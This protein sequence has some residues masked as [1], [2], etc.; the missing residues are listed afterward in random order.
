MPSTTA[1]LTYDDRRPLSHEAPFDPHDPLTG[2]RRNRSLSV[3]P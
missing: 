1:A 3:T 2:R